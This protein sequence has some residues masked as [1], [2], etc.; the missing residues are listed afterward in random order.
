MLRGFGV[1]GTLPAKEQTTVSKPHN[2]VLCLGPVNKPI[3][4]LGLES[5]VAEI[6]S[7]SADRKFPATSCLEGRNAANWLKANSSIFYMSL[8]ECSP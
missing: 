2:R 1:L 8:S 3:L 4:G 6:R 5:H 7:Y